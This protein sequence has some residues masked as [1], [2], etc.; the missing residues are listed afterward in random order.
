MFPDD[1]LSKFG[2]RYPVLDLELEPVLTPS[3]PVPLMIKES[4]GFELQRS[5]FP[6]RGAGDEARTTFPSNAEVV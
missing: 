5:S 3:G 2:Q 1:Q 4:N 6:L